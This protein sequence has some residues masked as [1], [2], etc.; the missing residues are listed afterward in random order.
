MDF[1]FTPLQDFVK[2]LSWQKILQLFLLLIMLVSSVVF[3]ENRIT[4]YNSVKVGS[5]VETDEPLIIVLSD[6][7]KAYVE[8]A[9]GRS[10][11]LVAGIQV[12]SV[13]FK[14]NSRA[15]TYFFGNDAVLKKDIDTYMANKIADNPMFTDSESN[16]QRV[17]NLING[18]FVCYDF[19]DTPGAKLY[20]DAA[21]DVTTVCSISIPPYYGR[22]SGYLNM[23]LLRKPNL[24]DLILIKQLER[25]IALR[26]YE[27]D[28][29]KP[30]VYGKP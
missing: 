26:I 28:I 18:D 12:V 20:P 24:D 1:N 17:V 7:T 16:N 4:I 15:Q 19:K 27:T 13:N 23:Y 8:S 29:D 10:K 9:V 11:D 25:D 3:W 22:F 6:S 21:K 5:R 14:K 30:V 2:S